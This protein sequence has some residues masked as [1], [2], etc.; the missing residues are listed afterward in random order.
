MII[1]YSGNEASYG[2]AV[3]LMIAR[4]SVMS[5]YFRLGDIGIQRLVKLSC[6]SND[7]E[8]KDAGASKEGE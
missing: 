7:E 8:D 1:Y 5:T 4:I 2:E 6:V 3:D